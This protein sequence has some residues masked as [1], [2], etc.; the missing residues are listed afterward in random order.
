[1][2]SAS[3]SM[4]LNYRRRVIYQ[5]LRDTFQDPN[6]VRRYF[7][8]WQRDHSH[9]THFVVTRFAAAVAKSAHFDVEHRSLFQRRLFHGL[10]QAYESLPRVPDGW[11]TAVPTTASAAATPAAMPSP[12][13][14]ARPPAAFAPAPT[15]PATLSAATRPPMTMSTT[16][17]A[18]APAVPI[19]APVGPETV[20]FAAFAQPIVAAVLAKADRQPGVLAS[21]VA[22]LTAGGDAREQ[23]LNR[24]FA[25]WASQRFAST[26]QP[27]ARA[28]EDL[29]FLAHQLYL[30]AADL[31]GPMQADRLLAQAATEADRLPEAARFSPQLL[32]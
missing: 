5:A 15:P 24:Q 13:P 19:V 32:L 1:V 2:S 16:P 11:L 31:I 20:V 25:Q 14:V 17:I 23:G 22:D 21:A 8:Q 29:R 26:V 10:T 6:E 12:P 3:E 9:E 18:P 7:D 4:G 30:L 27:T 28:P